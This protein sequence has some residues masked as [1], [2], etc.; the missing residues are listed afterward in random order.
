METFSNSSIS[1]F[2]F[3]HIFTQNKKLTKSQLQKSKHM[4][5][6]VGKIVI[7]FSQT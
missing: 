5:I 3:F 2:N 1:S 7:C 4:S 6:Y